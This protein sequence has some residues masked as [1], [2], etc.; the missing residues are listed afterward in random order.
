MAVLC[1]RAKRSHGAFQIAFHSVWEVGNGKEKESSQEE[2]P[3][4]EGSQEEGSEK[5]SGA[6]EEGRQ[7]KGQEEARQEESFLT[8]SGPNW[9]RMSEMDFAHTEI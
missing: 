7:E 5:E 4:E 1:S 2:G 6:K 3:Q 9:H 8:N